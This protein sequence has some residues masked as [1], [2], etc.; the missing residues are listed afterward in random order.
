MRKN[1]LISAARAAA[2]INDGDTLAIHASGGGLSEPTALFRALRDRYLE[3]G[4]P[5]GLHLFSASSIGDKMGNG[6]DLIA[7]P[8]LVKSCTAGHWALMPELGKLALEEKIQAYNYPQGVLSQM[9][10]AI[11]A[12]TPGVITKIGLNTFVD[13]RI[14]GGRMNAACGP[15]QVRVMDID[16]EE[17]LFYPRR[18]LNVAFVR[19]TTADP[20]G[21]ITSEEEA[22]VLDGI[23]AAQAVKNCGGIVVAQVKYL[24]ERGALRAKD[25]RIPGILVDYVV[26][27]PEQ[28]QTAETVYVPSLAGNARTPLAAIPALSL[29]ERKVVARRAAMELAPG[30]VVNLGFGMPDGVAAVTAEAGRLDDITFTLEQ[31]PIGGM[32]AGGVIFGCSYNPE[33]IIDA[34]QQFNFYDGGGLDVTFLGM[35]EMDR[36]GNVNAS[37]T[38]KLLS[39]CGGFINISQN[40][41]KVVFCSTFTAKGLK[42]C[43]GDGTF[44]VEREGEIPKFVEQVEQITFSAKNA[45]A[46]RQTVLVVTERAVFTL[47]PD[48][49]LL[50]EIAP[51]A[52]LDRDVIGRMRFRPLVSPDLKRMDASFFSA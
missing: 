11:A 7:L 32:P 1:K 22:V 36:F 17:Y 29:N 21:N 6:Y 30:A 51:G 34:T 46:N 41:K 18:H 15:A 16:G 24:A 25:V 40:A 50:I 12:K 14:E 20:D 47:T 2:L 10:M 33:A 49:L 4:K 52:D 19:G 23:S 39:G 37:R 43:I 35:A 3:E 48:G 9:Y 38:G 28:K 8:G 5:E 45:A 42:T 13:P 31:G 27:D 26:V 44:A